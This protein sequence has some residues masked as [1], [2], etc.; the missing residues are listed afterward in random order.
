MEDALPDKKL[1]L[2]LINQK[3]PF[4]KYKGTAIIDLPEYY[5]AW[6]NQKGFPK[7]RIGD[8]LAMAYDIKLNGLEK[9]VKALNS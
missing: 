6:F 4:G 8:L 5:L 1:L 9:M 3:M 2:D 7:G